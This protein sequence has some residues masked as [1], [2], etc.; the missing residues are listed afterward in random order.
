MT[1]RLSW[2]DLPASASGAIDVPNVIA[3]TS[4]SRSDAWAVFRYLDTGALKPKFK[5]YRDT[6]DATGTASFSNLVVDPA[7]LS[8]PVAAWVPT[9]QE[10]MKPIFVEWVHVGRMPF[11]STRPPS[12]ARHS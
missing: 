8:S 12:T 4:T 6:M 5:T 7:T 2:E 1:S 9:A 3:G 11:P 10:P